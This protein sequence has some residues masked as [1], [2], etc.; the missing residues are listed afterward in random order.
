MRPTLN[1]MHVIIAMAVVAKAAERRDYSGEWKLNAGKSN[2]GPLPPS[3]LSI[4]KVTHRGSTLTM[5][6]RGAGSDYTW[7]YVTDGQVSSYSTNGLTVQ[8]VAGWAGDG[9]AY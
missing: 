6:D 7:K 9:I 5:E 2:F 1:A 4:R 8:S 3:G